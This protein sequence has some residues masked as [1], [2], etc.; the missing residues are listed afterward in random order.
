MLKLPYG[1]GLDADGT[2]FILGKITSRVN[3]NTGEEETIL[4]KTVYPDSV[5]SA[6]R[7]IFKAKTRDMISEKDWDL[8]TFL[9]ELEALEQ[10]LERFLG[11]T[12]KDE[13]K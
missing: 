11:N 9:K 7:Y 2:T 12:V 4:T 1:Y 5:K 6:L 13:I 3:K 8:P 10:R